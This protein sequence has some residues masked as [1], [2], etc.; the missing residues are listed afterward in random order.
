MDNS[1]Y[2]NANKP[3]VKWVQHHLLPGM[4]GIWRHWSN[5]CNQGYNVTS[6]VLLRNDKC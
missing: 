1:S 2:L 5:C 4:Y 3:R 6:I